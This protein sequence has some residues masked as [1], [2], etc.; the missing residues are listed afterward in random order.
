MKT[1]CAE[2]INK[3]LKERILILDGAMGTSIQRLGLTEEDF[4]GE[5]FRDHPRNL[6]GNN[7][8]L[9]LTRPD[10][11]VGLHEAYLDAGADIIETC[12]FNGTV[13]PQAEY[14]VESHVYQLNLQAAKLARGACDKAELKDPSRPRFTAGCLGP[15]GKT[16]SMS[17]R[18][19]DPAW[20][21]VSFSQMKESYKTAATGLI[22]GGSDLLM[23]ET[24]FDSLNAKSALLAI[25]ELE[26][27]RGITIP[28]IISGTITDASGRTLS[29]QTAES[30]WH[31]L[32]YVRPVAFGFNCAL[33]ARELKSHVQTL[34]RLADCAVSTHP[35]A[36]L[37]DEMGQYQ[38]SPDDMARIL[39]EFA[40][41]GLVNIVGGCCGTTPDHIKAIADALKGISP[42]I[43]PE[44]KRA[45]VYTG[46]EPVLLSEG[47]FFL[48]IGERTNVAGSRKFARLIREKQYEEAL[49]I[50]R[51]QVE[52]GAAVIDINLD[53]AMLDAET[54]MVNLLH[55]VASEPEISR[56]PVM[57]DSSRWE[58]LRKGM[59]CLQGKSII[60]S[61]SLKEGEASFL[62]KA[63]KV[64]D[65]GCAVVVMAFDEEGQADTLERKLSICRRAWKTLRDKLDFPVE[66]IIFDVNVF[67]VAT[68]IPEHRDFGRSF[69]EAVRILKQELTGARFS[70]GISNLSFSFRGNEPVRQAMHAVFLYHAVLAGLDMGIVNAGQLSVYDNIEPSLRDIIEDV[71]LNRNPESEEKL[72]EEAQKYLGGQQEAG[73]EILADSLPPDEFLKNSLIKGQTAGIEDRL[74]ALIDQSMPPLAIIENVLM[75]GMNRIGE[76][77]GSG[78][79]FL[80]QVVKS[81]RVMKKAVAWLE[82]FMDSAGE[83]RKSGPVVVMAT[84]KG[85]VHDIGKNIVGVVLQC[86][87]CRVIDLGVMVPRETIMK[88]VAEHKADILGLSGL[89]TPSLEEMADVATE[90]EKAGLEIPL[91]IGGATTSAVHTAVKIAPN[92][93][94]PVVHVHDASRAPGVISSLM[95]PVHR[96]SWIAD[97]KTTQEDLR[98]ARLESRRH[99][100]PEPLAVARENKIPFD[101]SSYCPVNPKKPGFHL[102][103]DIPAKDLLP[104]FEWPF[105][106]LSCGIKGQNPAGDRIMA[107]A[108]QRI[109]DRGGDFKISVVFA[110]LPAQSENDT[111]TL[112]NADKTEV[113]GIF[114]MIRQQNRE[115]GESYFLS[116]ADFV[117]PVKSDGTPV[118]HAG[119]FAATVHYQG[120]D[121]DTDDPYELMIRE[122]LC[123]RLVEAA[124]E[125]LESLIAKEYWGFD[126][127]LLKIVRPGPGYPSTPDHSDK[128]RI[129][130]LLDASAKIGMTLT[131]THMMIPTASVAGFIF[132]HPQAR[133]FTVHGIGTDQL[134]D[135]SIRKGVSEKETEKWLGIEVLRT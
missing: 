69:I 124:S 93:H 70:G 71:I 36:G 99:N 112:F 127:E 59:E 37:P 33:G 92:Y 80:P 66:D 24:I 63:R 105:F 116:H 85:D 62:G 31:T 74:Q 42:R 65:M 83:P 96:D 102:I 25:R 115:P 17:S 38:E 58:V 100:K 15:T 47:S 7:D 30:F 81:A 29:G 98:A 12:T 9:C 56:V 113:L 82:P 134:I 108:R 55:L 10:V 32:S 135:L 64:R 68:G 50:A 106:L 119:C 34:A 104:L 2:L 61:L 23:V 107:E 26:T 8:I 72:I 41:E 77:F 114:P 22:D 49:E 87:G 3:L 76:L 52:G 84:V 94:G 53:D 13:I 130:A 117:S 120:K 16:L 28:L 123:Y 118:D 133:Y 20:R 18:V 54:E 4:R 75:A 101:W 46:L 39:A 43:I 128:S 111:I 91:L 1:D 11:V 35:N 45:S 79:M 6:K 109:L 97:L 44:S 90:M 40:R 48:N 73:T 88:A 57:I 121:I 129:A 132:V 5:L 125:N 86:N 67:A 131:E 60:N 95:N 27:E 110:L 103:K 89:I 78:K 122:A 14:G 19:E 51:E 21:D 126:S